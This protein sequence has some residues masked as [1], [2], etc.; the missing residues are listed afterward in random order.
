MSGDTRF[1]KLEGEIVAALRRAPGAEP[2]ADLDARIRARAHAAVAKPARRPQPIWFSMAAGLVVLVGSGLALRIWQQVEHAPS[3][4]D[5]PAPAATAPAAQVSEGAS[6]DA[7]QMESAGAASADRAEPA[8]IEQA[9]VV[10]APAKPSEPPAAELR[11]DQ[12]ALEPKREAMSGLSANAE[13]A[14]SIL[15]APQARPFPAEPAPALAAPEE[16]AA[17][18]SSAPPASAKVAPPP[19]SLPPPVAAPAAAPAPMQA[20][21]ADLDKISTQPAGAGQDDA[22]QARSVEGAVVPGA[23]AKAADGPE[24]D[25]APAR[26]RAAGEDQVADPYARALAAV[27]DAIAAGDID[28]AR[29]L[30]RDLRRDYPERELP[31]DIRAL[32][33]PAQ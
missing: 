4:L 7:A 28:Q 6:A 9:P 20:P 15:P 8:R 29:Q 1:D 2:S 19:A 14:D 13:M 33:D 27:R 5:A 16:A 30:A 24:R 23:A 17:T 21:T 26:Q 25:G 22:I 12:A 11:R 31:E 10:A 3:A 32:V 18:A